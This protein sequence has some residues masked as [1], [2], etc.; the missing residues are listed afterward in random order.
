[1]SSTFRGPL[2]SAFLRNTFGFNAEEISDPLGVDGHFG[3]YRVVSTKCHTPNES[4]FGIVEMFGYDKMGENS[5][6]QISLLTGVSH[7][8]GRRD[9]AI[10]SY[11]DSL[12]NVYLR[13]L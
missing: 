5:S 6:N 9:R 8:P 13:S 3:V 10:D 4:H 12:T 11:F 2:K 1:M 7:I